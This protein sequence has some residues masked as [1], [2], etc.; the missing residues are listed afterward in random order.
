MK[1][2]LEWETPAIELIS[3]LSSQIEKTNLFSNDTSCANLFLLQN[4]Y[5]IEVAVT[6]EFLFRYFN[7]GKTRKGYLFPLALKPNANLDR[8]IKLIE[9]DA[10]KNSRKIKFCLVTAEQKSQLD[11]IISID[12][13]TNR[14]DS[15]YIYLTE[16]LST[17]SGKDFHKKKNHLT[18]FLNEY[19]NSVRI[20]ELCADDDEEKEDLWSDALY[21]ADEW[22][23]KAE[24]SGEKLEESVI[25][26]NNSI[27]LAIENHKKLGLCGTIIY[28]DDE[29]AAMTIASEISEQVLDVHYEKALEEYAK[30]GAY[31]A[32]NYF[33][34]KSHRE[35]M[36]LNREEDMG[37]EGLRKSKLSY[38]PEIILDKFY[39][40]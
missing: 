27:H 24:E 3:Q 40:E 31:T 32:I 37:I 35:H 11:R 2:T 39:G 6:D 22:L 23:S 14:N 34:A 18:H 38:R 1:T 21:I 8:A 20:E 4:K 16:E 30:E 26:E 28:V 19:G 12:W 33:F 5:D 25:E 13:D 10:R 36:Y 7:G 29:P 9:Q 15:D 17:L